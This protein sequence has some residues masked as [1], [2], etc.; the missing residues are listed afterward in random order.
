MN[1]SV[2]QVTRLG[3][4]YFSCIECPHYE[5]LSCIK[6]KLDTVNEK[7]ST[8]DKENKETNEEAKAMGA[9]DVGATEGAIEV[10]V[11]EGVI[12][13]VPQTDE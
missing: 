5:C 2:C 10:G 6:R 13:V 8:E 7:T 11:T 4:G 12:E 1:C 3:S 9:I